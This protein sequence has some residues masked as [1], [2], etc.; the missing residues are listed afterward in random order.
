MQEAAFN[1]LSYGVDGPEIMRPGC[2]FY[3]L[4]RASIGSTTWRLQGIPLSLVWGPWLRWILTGNSEG[5]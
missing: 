3:L 4:R 1:Q 5:S 2:G